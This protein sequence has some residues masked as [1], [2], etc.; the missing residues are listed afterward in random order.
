MKVMGAEGLVVEVLAALTDRAGMNVVGDEGNHLGPVELVVNVLDRLGDAR[1]T[2]KA[3]I[4]MQVEDVQS[5]IL[6]IRDIESNSL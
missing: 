1:V 6:I 3:V 4:V 5:D 2:S